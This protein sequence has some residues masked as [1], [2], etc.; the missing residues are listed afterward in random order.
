MSDRLAN[1]TPRSL[2]LDR[3]FFRAL[4][5]T[6][7]WKLFQPRTRLTNGCLKLSVPENLS[8]MADS[9]TARPSSVDARPI[10]LSV[11]IMG[12]AGDFMKD[13]H[14]EKAGFWRES[15]Y[16]LRSTNLDRITAE[17]LVWI[18]FL[19]SRFFSA[20]EGYEVKQ[21]LGYATVVEAHN[22]LMGII[23]QETGFDFAKKADSSRKLYWETRASNFG[24][25]AFAS[26]V[27]RSIGCKSFESP[28]RSIQLPPPEWTP[29]SAYVTTF[30]ATM[31][32][33]YYETFKNMLRAWPNR[34]P[35]DDEL[36]DNN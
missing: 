10:A 15:D 17:A 6:M 3:D 34:F 23:E 32:E 36:T 33:A 35:T 4:V 30:F 13:L 9:M 16:Y 29:L 14:W 27:L 20:E 24:H 11:V 25:E 12:A 22:L 19:M 31:P 7:A 5:P 26:V 1:Q 21:R 28:E 2:K 8:K 18:T